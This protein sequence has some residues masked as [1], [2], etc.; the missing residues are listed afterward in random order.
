MTFI[1]EKKI[2]R[3]CLNTKV[4]KKL[5]CNYS[6]KE[7][8]ALNQAVKYLRLVFLFRE[9]FIFQAANNDDVHFSTKD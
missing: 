1:S 9:K 3:L 2:E 4:M 8:Q 7:V 6:S 5:V